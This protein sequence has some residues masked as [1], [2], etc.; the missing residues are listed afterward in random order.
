MR[1]GQRGLIESLP[2]H[3]SI[4]N[5][6]DV[7]KI[8][9][10]IGFRGYTVNDIVDEGQ[11]AISL[12]PSN[13]QNSELRLEKITFISWE[14]WEE[15]P[16]IKIENG[17]IILV[18]TGSTVGKAAIVK[19]LHSPATLNPQLVV[20]KKRRIDEQFLGYV[21]LSNAFQRQLAATVV[22]GALPTLSQKEVAAYTFA[23]PDRRDEQEAIATALKDIDDLIASLDALIA[24]KRDIK[25]AAMQQLLTGK[26]RLPG[27]E[28]KSEDLFETAVGTIPSDWSVVRVRDGLAASPCYG[29]NAPS[30]PFSFSLPTYLR[31]TDIDDDGHLNADS[32]TS[33]NHPAS[34][35]Y[36]LE[37]GDIVIARTGAST[38]KAYLHNNPALRFVYA[39]F[40]I[41]L[42]PNTS[43]LLPAFLSAVLRTSRYWAWIREVSQR[44]GQ[45]GVNAQQLSGFLIPLPSPEEQS[46]IVSVLESMDAE[47][48]AL[49]EKLQ[50]F[51]AMKDGMMQQLLTGRIRL[52]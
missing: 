46:E 48:L 50:K 18:K 4:R 40:L 45:P 34:D 15:S 11:G 9:G 30:V 37:V 47:I 14:K 27:F 35:Q 16:E 23:C 29:I 32:L 12:S 33:V 41:R 2:N 17:D 22:G 28:I 38:G 39:G 7:C 20:L 25:Q 31:I 6:G 43:V 36:E 10:R 44:S 5:I 3:W 42:R 21:V 24:K 8:F 52:V 49:D 26:T 1:G 13:I 51:A 19:G